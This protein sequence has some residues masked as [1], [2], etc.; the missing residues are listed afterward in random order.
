MQ[1]AITDIQVVGNIREDATNVA[2]LVESINRWGVIVPLVVLTDNNGSYQLVAGHR[3]LVAAIEAGL[4]HV[5]VVVTEYIESDADKIA[6][7]YHE[8]VM[9]EDLTAWEEAQATFDLNV[10]GLD[11]KAIAVELG[12]SQ[13]EVDRRVKVARTFS[14]LESHDDAKGLSHEALF[15]LADADLTNEALVRALETVAGGES[16]SYSIR[17]AERTAQAAQRERELVTLVERATQ[18]GATFVDEQPARGEQI[19]RHLPDGPSFSNNLGWTRQ[20]IELHRLED[21]H[22]YYV[23]SGYLGDTLT[24]YCK[25][26]ARH[27]EKGKSELKEADAETKATVKAE[28][29]A[30]RKEIKEAKAARLA[31]VAGILLPGK[32]RQAEVIAE[33]LPSLVGLSHDGCRVLCKALDLEPIKSKFGDTVAYVAM[34]DKWLATFPA[35]KQVYAEVIAT[36]AVDYI[37]RVAYTA[38]DKAMHAWFDGLAT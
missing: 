37:E 30:V 19:V 24:E 6:M 1:V 8:N 22:V 33:V 17:D 5:P 14:G 7:Q 20:E 18:D 15:D 3:R 13:R 23:Q 35:N 12:I 38:D 32:W 16:T 25:S 26:P 21:C 31:T 11:K 9:R 2:G 29:R 34:V 28:E 10:E 4:T 27:R 36:A